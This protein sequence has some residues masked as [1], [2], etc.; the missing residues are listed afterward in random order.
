MVDGCHLSHAFGWS[1]PK[2][3]HNCT[4]PIGSLRS[5]IPSFR[6]LA[7]LPPNTLPFARVPSPSH[8][9]HVP[10]PSI[11]FGTHDL[12]RF[13]VGPG[14]APGLHEDHA[15]GTSLNGGAVRSQMLF[16]CDTLEINKLI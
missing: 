9:G 8:V 1:C 11:G 12:H 14:D 2:W 7:P 4:S 16:S 13:G 3:G 15:D 10:F 6:L 5:C